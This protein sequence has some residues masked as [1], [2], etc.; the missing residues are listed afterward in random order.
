[1]DS[2]TLTTRELRRYN[3]Q[4]IVPGIGVEGQEKLKNSSVLIVG[5][6]G[7]GC[8]VLQYL[9]SAGIGRIGIVEFDMVEEA[10]LQRQV[11][12][13]TM[14]VGKLKSIIVKD[15]LKYLNDLITIEL[16]NLKLASRNAL[17]ILNQFDLIIDAT[18]N[19]GARYL[20]N[21]ACIILGKPMI[22]GAI[23]LHEGQVSVFNYKG[24]PTYRCYNPY[25]YN[26]YLNPEPL[27]TGLFGVLPGIT[28]TYMASEAIKIITWI[29]DVLSGKILYF[30]I[31]SNNSY[32]IQINNIP[33]NHN[34]KELQNDY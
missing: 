23:Y 22:H 11:L 12:Y 13:G 8:P 4:I 31:V 28:G 10:N 17:E 2:N 3:R 27:E 9:A 5:A 19:Y 20:I 7:L 16:F 26:R 25:D 29:G 33:E 32:I 30:N 21:D 6:G 15:R 1:M 14:D 34:I 18:D 24:G